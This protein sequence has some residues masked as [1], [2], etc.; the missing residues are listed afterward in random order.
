MRLKQ[1]CPDCRPC[2]VGNPVRDVQSP[3]QCA[4]LYSGE[5]QFQVHFDLSNTIGTLFGLAR[6]LPSLDPARVV[7]ASLDGVDFQV[8][9]PTGLGVCLVW[10]LMT[11]SHGH[12]SMLLK[13]LWLS[14]S[15]ESGH[16]FPQARAV[17]TS[18]LNQKKCSSRMH[19]RPSRQGVETLIFL[20]RIGIGELTCRSGIQHDK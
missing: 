16:T 20:V 9:L 3:S 13:I 4:Q 17:L 6:K 14:L 8:R 12:I 2:R 19:I 11:A 10:M 5:G 18:V 15:S 1:S 7:A